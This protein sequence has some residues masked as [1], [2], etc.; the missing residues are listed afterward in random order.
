MNNFYEYLKKLD[1]FSNENLEQLRKQIVFLTVKRNYFNFRNYMKKYL[2][3]NIDE[4]IKNNIIKITD[5]KED[6]GAWFCYEDGTAWSLTMK[7]KDLKYP[8]VLY[9]KRH[10]SKHTYTI[11]SSIEINKMK[12]VYSRGD[13][14]QGEDDSTDGDIVLYILHKFLNIPLSDTNNM[15]MLLFYNNSGYDEY[16]VN[17]IEYFN[18]STPDISIEDYKESE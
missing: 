17:S 2:P 5:F 1:S 6:N 4:L 16:K 7:I 8:V 11:Y 14:S 18:K 12:F 13:F 15:L 9:Y 10:S 3:S